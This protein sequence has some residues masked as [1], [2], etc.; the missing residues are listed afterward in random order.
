MNTRNNT[1]QYVRRMRSRAAGLSVVELLVSLAISAW[2][3]AAVMV[4][5]NASFYAYA[6]AAETA[7]TQSSSRLVVQRLMQM[8]RNGTLQDA[9]D[10]NDSS[11]TLGSPSSP[12]VQSVGIQ[13]IDGQGRLVK[14]WWVVNGSYHDADLGDLMY[15]EDSS[16]AVP[17][18]ERVRIQRT[19]L[20]DPYLFSLASRQSGFG[21]LMSR[22]T[23]DLTVEPGADATLALESTQGASAPVR[24]V[25]SSMPRRNME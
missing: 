10:P 8:I 16:T 5:L 12:P 6:S 18:L 13:M 21:L 19:A 15:Q 17:I 23:I 2:L 7:S 11:V 14:I 20:D 9:Y 24:L 4:A 1:S 3:L 22:A 25:A